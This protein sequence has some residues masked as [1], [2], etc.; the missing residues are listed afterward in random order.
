MAR[1][2]LAA[3]ALLLIAAAA[4]AYDATVRL[5][6]MQ[7]DREALPPGKDGKP[8]G[9][10]AV[11]ALTPETLLKKGAPQAIVQEGIVYVSGTKVRMDTETDQGAYSIVVLDNGITWMIVPAEKRYIEWTEADA[12]AA[13]D[14]MENMKKLL[15][16]RLP[17]LPPDQRKQAEAVLKRIDPDAN[18]PTSAL[19]PKALD[20]TKTVHGMKAEGYRIKDGDT[21]VVGWITQDQPELTQALRLLTERMQKQQLAPGGPQK[22]VREI[23]QGKGL[24]V[25]VQTVEPD[26]Y[27][28]EEIISVD[29]KPLAADLFT[30]PKDFKKTSGSEVLNKIP[31]KLPESAP[32][33]P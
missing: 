11:L 16:E 8:P 22:T 33:A 7:V 25:L 28:I 21:T 3:S 12:K 26:V 27:R 13:A 1:N 17:S 4:P 10:D 32:A 15:K 31:D 2:V 6:T 23:L 30:V 5:R 20:Q 14:K 19:Q 24:P 18:V 9:T 29:Q